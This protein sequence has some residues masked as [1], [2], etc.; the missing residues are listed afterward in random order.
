MLMENP[1]RTKK[2]KLRNLFLE[3]GG[4]GNDYLVLVRN[5]ILQ[6]KSLLKQHNSIM[7]YY[8]FTVLCGN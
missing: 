3:E 2:Q 8:S 1:L 7:P 6:M 4:Y 5:V